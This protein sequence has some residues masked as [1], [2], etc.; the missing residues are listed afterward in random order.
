MST[1]IKDMTIDEI[2]DHCENV[3]DNEPKDSD[4][5][6]EHY[7]TRKLLFDLQ[8]I[9]ED[10]QYKLGQSVWVMMGKEDDEYSL[11]SSEYIFM[12]TCSDYVIVTPSST[13]IKDNFKNFKRQLA[14]MFYKSLV[15]NANIKIFHK[16]RVHQT[17]EEAEKVIKAIK[18]EK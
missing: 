1:E 4:L 15:K 3:L 18:G 10:M 2:I 7:H 11:Y 17:K 5:Y 14:K 6:A 16:R 12:A 9:Q 13:K 8:D